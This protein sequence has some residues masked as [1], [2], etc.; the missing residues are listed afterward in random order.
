MI[1][2][3]AIKDYLRKLFSAENF[4]DFCPNGLQVEGK[5]VVK[6]ILTAVSADLETIEAAVQ[7]R[8]DLLIVH[9]GLFWNKDSFVIEGAKK[10]KIKLLLENEM[11]LFAY[12]LPMDA[13][14]EIGNN[15]KAAIDLGW[16]ELEPFGFMD[17][18]VKGVVDSLSFEEFLKTLENYYEHPAT[19]VRASG[20]S[21]KKVGL[22]SGG[23]H[24]SILEASSNELDAFITGSFDEPSWSQSKEENVHFYAMG[25]SATERVGPIALAKRIEK[26]LGVSSSFLDIRNPF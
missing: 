2:L 14:R 12:H 26:D 19:A 24:K 21:I 15:W 5:P 18:G 16:K 6:T 23:A 22:I 13:H 7:K 8:A 10:K 25:H 11:S 9:H 1:Y 20:K 3:K 4:S 17:L